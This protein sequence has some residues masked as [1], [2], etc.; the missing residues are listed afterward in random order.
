MCWQRLRS[1]A[2]QSTPTL[3]CLFSGGQRGV[4]AF[5]RSRRPAVGHGQRTAAWR[6]PARPA[7][8]WSSLSSTRTSTA[9]YGWH[10]RNSSAAP[11]QDTPTLT[12]RPEG[13]SS[14]VG[15]G[16]RSG[17]RIRGVL[18]GSGPGQSGCC[19]AGRI[20]APDLPITSTCWARAS[21]S[22]SSWTRTLLASRRCG[23]PISTCSAATASAP[24]TRSAGACGP[25]ATRWRRPTTKTPTSGCRPAGPAAARKVRL[26]CPVGPW[27]RGSWPARFRARDRHPPACDAGGRRRRGSSRRDASAEVFGQASRCA[28][29]WTAGYGLVGA[30]TTNWASPVS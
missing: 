22:T 20:P 15:N 23:T 28:G 2:A 25:C 21:V 24:P 1:S 12:R 6:T 26:T 3:C 13:V 11:S 7:D 16:S 18:P 5:H 17:R 19:S 9:T 10:A 29:T 4:R 8:A 14:T 30:F 27:H